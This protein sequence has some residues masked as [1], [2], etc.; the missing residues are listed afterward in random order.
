MVLQRETGSLFVN[1][2]PYPDG[3]LKK[4]SYGRDVF[5]EYVYHKGLISEKVFTIFGKKYHWLRGRDYLSRPIEDQLPNG[6]IIKY[7]YDAN[8]RLISLESLSTKGETISRFDYDYSKNGSIV[9]KRETFDYL[10]TEDAE[11]DYY[12][13]YDAANR[14]VDSSYEGI[15]NLDSMGNNIL[16]GATYNE[17]NQLIENNEWSFEY[18]LDGNLLKKTSKQSDLAFVYTWNARDLLVKVEKFAGNRISLEL[19]FKYDPLG[20]RIEKSVKDYLKPTKSYVKRYVYDGEDI[21]LEL[22]EKNAIQA[23]F[24]HG[25]GVDSPIAMLRDEN[26]NG[27]FEDVELFVFT[28]DQ[29]GSVREIVDSKQNVL[30]RYTYSSY[31]ETKLEKISSARQRFVDSPYGY[32]SREWDQETGD[33]FYRARYYDPGTGRFLAPDPIGFGGGDTNYY[34]YVLNNPLKYTDPTGK[35][36]EWLDDGV[37]YITGKCSPSSID[38]DDWYDTIK[39]YIDDIAKDKDNDD[40]KSCDDI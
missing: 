20:R 16:G 35:W 36:P 24:L 6:A 38:S 25:E 39:K 18:D 3:L 29:L 17:F 11:K 9:R 12:Y 37:C 15:F 32:T 30:Q 31:G 26:R 2:T 4:I 1:T 14:L 34:R 8:S 19:T 10:S 13:Q 21:F 5:V 22:D 28:K 7:N 27:K 33:Y 40:P 23:I